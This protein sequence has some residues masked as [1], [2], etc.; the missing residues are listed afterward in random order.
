MIDLSSVTEIPNVVHEPLVL[1]RLQFG[2]AH[3]TWD[4]RVLLDVFAGV[5]NLPQLAQEG[6][7]VAVVE[8]AELGRDCVGSLFSTVEGNATV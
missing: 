3:G 6:L 4:F 8:F 7:F 5:P 1:L 2:P